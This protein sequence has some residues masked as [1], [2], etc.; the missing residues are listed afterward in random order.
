M[1]QLRAELAQLKHET[2]QVKHLQDDIL[3]A[4]GREESRRRSYSL[5]WMEWKVKTL[6][7]D[8][9]NRRNFGERM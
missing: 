8:N 7:Q 5:H 1:R 4:I 6:V 2:S 3:S 9:V